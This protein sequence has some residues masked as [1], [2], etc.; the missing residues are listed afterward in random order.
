M[1]SL[2]TSLRRIG[3]ESENGNASM[4]GIRSTKDVLIL[5]TPKRRTNDELFHEYL[6]WTTA[7]NPLR[8]LCPNFSYILGAFKCL[9]PSIA[10]DKSVTSW[11]EANHI[12][13]NHVVNYVIYEKV[14]GEPIESHMQTCSATTFFSWFVQ[15]C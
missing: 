12:D 2:V 7:T 14:P 1:H 10:D 3:A 9:P 15:I 5:K 4:V 6:V 11:C 13:A 8:R